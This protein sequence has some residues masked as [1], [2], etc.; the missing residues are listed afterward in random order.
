MTLIDAKNPKS[1][2]LT[3][4]PPVYF[5]LKSEKDPEIPYPTISNR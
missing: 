5:N 2:A 3:P 4:P 1:T